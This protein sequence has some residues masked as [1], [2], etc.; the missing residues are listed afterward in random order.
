MCVIAYDIITKGFLQIRI[1]RSVSCNIQVFIT[2]SSFIYT[3]GAEVI[4]KCCRTGAHFFY[5]VWILCCIY[6]SIKNALKY[7]SLGSGW[8]MRSSYNCHG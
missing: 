1:C 7:L 5:N 3:I 8:L 6:I 4:E 2:A